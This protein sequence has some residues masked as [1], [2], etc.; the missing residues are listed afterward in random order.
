MIQV[1]LELENNKDFPALLTILEKFGAT[2]KQQ[3]VIDSPKE[4]QLMAIIDKGVAN[5]SFGD[6]SSYQSEIR[7]DRKLPYRD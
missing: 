6:A 5:S 4:E 1:I 2:I 7:K 3:Q